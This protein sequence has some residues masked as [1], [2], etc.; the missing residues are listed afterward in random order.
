MVMFGVEADSIAGRRLN[1][2]LRDTSNTLALESVLQLLD[3]PTEL[4][5][6]PTTGFDVASISTARIF[7]NEDEGFAQPTAE[8][9]DEAQISEALDTTFPLDDSAAEATFSEITPVEDDSFEDDEEIEP[10]PGNFPSPME[11]SYRL[12]ATG[13]RVTLAEW[14]DAISE[15]HIPFEYTHM[16]FPEDALDEEEDFLDSEP[17]DD[18]EGPYE[19]DRDF[20]RDDADQPVGRRVFTPEEE[21]AAL[22]HLR[23][24]LAPHSAKSATEQSAA[25]QSVA[26]QSEATPAEDAQSDAVRSDAARS[27][28]AQSENVS[29]EDTPLQAT[30]AAPSAGSV[31]KKPASKNSALEKRLTDEQIRAKTRRVGLVLGA[32]VTA[33]SAIALTLANVARRRRA[34]GKASRKFSVAAALFALNATVESALIPTVLRSFERTQMK[35]HARPVADAELVHP[36]DTAG[37]RPSTKRTLIDDLRE[38]HYRTVED[39]APSTEQAP[40]GLR[41]RALGIVCSIRLRAAKKTDR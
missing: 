6:V 5:L 35:K 31:S 14:M 37:E 26:S 22:A 11:R 41:E 18:F 12:V 19:Q 25:E 30:Q 8:L 7:G 2:Y 40:S 38:G 1:A 36:G 32:D 33:Q 27:D 39:A 3:V 4:A 17:F 24:A 29:A 20:D 34:Q 23:A 13:R 10:Y 16:S 21:E 15:G 9:A 28:D